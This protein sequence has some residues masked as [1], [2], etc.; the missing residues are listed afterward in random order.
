MATDTAI[1][2]E[3]DQLNAHSWRT[4][5]AIERAPDAAPGAPLRNAGQADADTGLPAVL[6][7][8]AFCLL[9][10]VAPV[11]GVLWQMG[12]RP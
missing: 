4:Y 8:A 2:D 12:V 1:S 9:L 7:F 11:C 3:R 6:A 5:P 10:A